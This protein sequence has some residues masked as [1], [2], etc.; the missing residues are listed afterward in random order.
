MASREPDNLDSKFY[1]TADAF[2]SAYSHLGLTFDDVTLATLYSEVLPRDTQLDTTL[3]EGLQLNIPIISS[4]MDT[5]TEARMAIAMALNGGL[6]LIHYNMPEREQL[7]EVSRVK[8]N[9]HGLIQDPVKAAPDQ[10]IG[11]V[12]DLIA[13]RRFAFSTFPVVD[14]QGKLVGLLPGH[15]VKQRYASRKVAEALIPRSELHMLNKKDLGRD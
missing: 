8:N 10:L 6:G 2:F 14:G 13:K 5:V 12:L 7:S 4:D 9:V 11:D 3:A 1:K 15:V